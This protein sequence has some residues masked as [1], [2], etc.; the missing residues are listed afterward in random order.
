MADHNEFGRSAEDLAARV[1]ETAG[2]R[3]LDRNWRWRR[4]EI[5]IVAIRDDVVAFVEVRARR[6]VGH[7]HPLQTIDWR[8]RRRLE[9]AARVWMGLHGSRA[10]DCRF[11]AISIHAPAGDLGRARTEHIEGAWRMGE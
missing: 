8:K 2:W 9:Q 6:E 1:L 5:D 4:R 11:D 10:F 3:I 7:G